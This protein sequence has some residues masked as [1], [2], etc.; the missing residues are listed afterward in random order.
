MV[1]HGTLQD[2]LQLNTGRAPGADKEYSLRWRIEIDRA[3]AACGCTDA[4][5]MAHLG[6]TDIISYGFA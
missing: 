1:F 3:P 4:E 2:A 6:R 5:K